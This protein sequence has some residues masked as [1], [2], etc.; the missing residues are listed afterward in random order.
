MAT[1][2]KI[3]EEDKYELTKSEQKTTATYKILAAENESL[4]VKLEDT[5]NELNKT[6][7]IQ[8][9]RDKENSILKYRLSSISFIE[10][11]KFGSTAFIGVA[12]AYLVASEYKTAL[13][14]GVPAIIIF[15]V[16]IIFS[17]KK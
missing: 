5:Q 12:G 3:I 13:F 10:F 4:K 16:I 2:N 1:K 11:L 14:I 15:G 6:K 8:V 7:K 17:N 9:E